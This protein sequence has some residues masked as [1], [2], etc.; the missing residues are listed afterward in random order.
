MNAVRGRIVR[1][2]TLIAASV[3]VAMLGTLAFWGDGLAD[4]T[5]T[6]PMPPGAVP[7][8]VLGDSNSHS[9]QDR[10]GFPPGSTERG[11]ARR[12]QTFQWIEVLARLRGAELDPGPW[13]A[14][15]RPGNVAWARELIGLSAGR[16]P[17]KEDYLYNF[18]NSGAACKNLM[19][20]R[21]GQ[22]FRQAP[23][24]VELMDREPAR[25]RNGLVV[26]RIGHN[27]WAGLLD[28]Q[29]QNPAAP[30]L[31]AATAYCVGQIEAAIRLIHSRHPGTR[32]LVA[33]VINEADDPAQFERY[34]SA[35]ETANL[36]V[37]L[38]S[39][40]GALQRIAATDPRLAFFDEAGW[41]GSRWG[42]RDAGGSP[43]YKTVAIGT[44]LRVTNT[45]GDAPDNALLEDH[46]A[47]L[48]WNALLA[49]ALVGRL[50]D[51]FQLPLTP[52][53]DDE[54][55]RFVAATIKAPAS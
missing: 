39:F 14:W 25:W 28:L 7:I 8:A 24:L 9:Y 44:G 4:G 36:K 18:A 16:A 21:R 46:H 54:L 15:G 34:R 17:K 1:V 12:A 43:A 47:G 53:G 48:A 10:I 40:N 38:A 45:A 42:A 31:A 32:V 41:F 3:C 27:D 55:A 2:G 35:S 29:A 51:A 20:D 19:G 23:R 50:K 11:G 49:Q 13:V 22:R 37:S 52:I 26:I 6:R 30:E 5:A 33:G